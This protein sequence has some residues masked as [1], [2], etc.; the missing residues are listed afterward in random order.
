M[1]DSTPAAAQAA[2]IA[3]QTDV[4]RAEKFTRE[5]FVHDGEDVAVALARGTARR[6]AF[7]AALRELDEGAKV[8]ST[9]WRRR[10]ALLLGLERLLSE[11]EP[12]L[13]D[14]TTLNPHQVDALSGTLTALLAAAQ[15]GS[16]TA[17]PTAT[18][19]LAIEEEPAPEPEAPVAEDEPEPED[20][21]DLEED[22]DEDEDDDDLPAAAAP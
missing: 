20:D 11:D 22:D 12:R 2:P 3:E 17:A 5:R 7:D 18:P 4:L 19:V 10:Y 21:D 8:P 15:N 6:R 13:E 9:K 1:A 16:S 14:G